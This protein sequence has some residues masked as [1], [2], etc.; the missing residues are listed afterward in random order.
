MRK[1]EKWMTMIRKKL[2]IRKAVKKGRPGYLEY[3]LQMEILRTVIYFAIVAA[4]FWLGYSQTHSNQNLLTVVA[5]VGCLPASKALVGVITRLPHRSMEKRLVRE[6]REKSASLTMIYDLV[7]TSKEK[8]M[9]VECIAISGDKILG[10]TSSDKVDTAYAVKFVKEILAQNQIS[11][12]N[13]QLLHQYGDF[14]SHLEK[15]NKAVEGKES[16]KEQERQIANVI[17]NI[18]L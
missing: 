5:V 11:K 13:M 4:L 7:L 6:I 16:P 10:Y 15:M 17:L 3:K 1:M 9:P 2:H 8:I 18:S 12:T 14:L